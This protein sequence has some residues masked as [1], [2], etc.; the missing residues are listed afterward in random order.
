MLYAKPVE[1]IF[2]HSMAGHLGLELTQLVNQFNQQQH[3]FYIKLVYKGEYTDS[4]TSFAAAYRAHQAPAMIQVFEVGTATMLSMPGVIKPVQQLMDEQD[5][6]LP[7][8]DFLPAIRAF[9]SK[10]GQLQA[11]P[12]NTSI[13]VIF[14]NADALAKLGVDE[15]HFPKTWDGLGEMIAKLRQSGY[16]CGYTSAYPSWVQIESFL[17]LHGLAL[18]NHRKEAVYDNAAV[19]KHL[20]RLK[21]WQQKHYFEYG[22]RASDATV[23]FTSGRCVLFSQSSGSYNSMIELAPFRLGVAS[24]PLDTEVSNQRHNNVIGGAALWVI[25]G[26]S[27]QVEKGIA[28]FFV[29]LAEEKTQAQWYHQTGYIPLGVSGKYQ[30]LGE[31]PQATLRL[32]QLELGRITGR[33][34]TFYLGPQ[35]LIRAVNDEALEA[36]FAGSKTAT[37]AIEEAVQ[38]ANYL[39]KRFARNNTTSH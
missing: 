24:L 4:L 19:K 39:L 27:P 11:M 18:T 20:S 26:Q 28:A 1:V 5:L 21:D 13:P 8:D 12:F 23:L 30:L 14:Y 10:H 17:A 34:R 32:A 36:I 16:A 3:R 22:G 9:Y 33:P 37:Q 7:T 25:A 38:R 31:K 15:A 29:Y 2:W 35:N 6:T